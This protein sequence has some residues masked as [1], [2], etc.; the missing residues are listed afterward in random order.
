MNPPKHL[1]NQ[2]TLAR[3]VVE[4]LD[5]AVERGRTVDRTLH[6]F[7][8]SRKH[9][10]SRDRRLLSAVAFSHFRWLGW[11]KD[12]ALAF[13]LDA[14]ERN[15][16]VDLLLAESELAGGAS[17]E[18]ALALVQ[19]MGDASF[20]EKAAA[21]QAWTGA[22]EPPTTAALFP[23]WVPEN[24]K[25]PVFQSRPPVW[26]RVRHHERER[27]FRRIEAI[28]LKS[29]VHPAQPLAVSSPDHRGVTKLRQEVQ[30]LMEMQTLVSQVAG[31]VCDPQPGEYWWDACCGA[32]G[33]SLH[34]NE[35]MK[36]KGRIL[37]S[38]TR[39][40]AINQ[41]RKR[42]HRGNLAHIEMHVLDAR[43][44]NVS[45]QMFNGILADA[46]C[47][48]IGTWARNPDA[49]WR[50]RAKHVDFHVQAQADI[51][52]NLARNLQ[53][54]GR[55]VY[56]VCTLTEEETSG[57]VATFLGNHAEFEL[58]PFDNPLDGSA[59]DGTLLLHPNDHQGDGMYIARFKKTDLA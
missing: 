40:D 5:G 10:G 58:D 12:P 44:E 35:L 38:D 13:Y 48:G 6:A 46:P 32:G 59:T 14:A 22:D 20:E 16:A 15:G 25:L 34:L 42:E 8:R 17:G 11:T 55:L 51:L 57:S 53:P 45:D 28:G 9:L 33:K 3:E 23:A 43:V 2:A 49:R 1:K 52:H 37:A 41:F 29:T 50:L 31:L 47:T 24:L 18:D 30:G 4:H 21:F 7:Y 56:A 39:G 19:P 27:V 54:G 26:L 36:Y